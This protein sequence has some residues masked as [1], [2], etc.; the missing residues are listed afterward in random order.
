MAFWSA[1]HMLKPIR[2]LS[3][4]ITLLSTLHAFA[5]H[6]AQDQPKAVRVNGKQAAI[7]MS[8]YR[9]KPV[10]A[11][12]ID[13]KGP[14]QFFMDTGAGATV[15]DKTL[16]DEIGLKPNGT[17]KLGDP[18]SPQAVEATKR[19][20]GKLTIGD[21]EFLDFDALSM[22]R[23]LLYEAGAPRGV[24]GLPLFKE[25]LF[26]ID[27]PNS[28]VVIENGKLP[29]ANGREILQFEFSTGGIFEIPISVDGQ[30]LVAHIDSGSPGGISFPAEQMEKLR[31]T[32]K[33]VEAGR[34]RTVAG[35]SVIY[36][37]KMAGDIL[38]GS[39]KLEA[40]DVRFF[41]RLKQVN[42]GYDFLRRFAITV[43]QKS[44]SIRFAQAAVT[45]I[46]TASKPTQPASIY[47]G[48]FGVRRVFVEADGLY[49]QRI[50]GPQGEGP[51]LKLKEIRPD[52]FAIEIQPSEVRVKF[53]RSA[54]GEVDSISVL[55]PNGEWET[56][57]RT[58]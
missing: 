23:A 29:T 43:D 35:E 17:I 31:L 36:Q 28:R 4:L 37:A 44:R 49:L 56:S 39:Y 25:L 5:Q 21:A 45:A 57:K 15:I 11:V 20:I 53:S 19:R 54:N 42:L 27:Y 40:P 55:A 12:M 46:A 34:G 13:G 32:N 22:D 26:T 50:S 51:K 8:L 47:A 16:A 18:T 9:N 24:L 14:F 2:I 41:G 33:P 38:V 48:I 52:E 30:S 7:Q 10:V 6:P 3:L 58:N 1:I